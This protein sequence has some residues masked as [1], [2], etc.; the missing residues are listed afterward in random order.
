MRMSSRRALRS[1]ESSSACS[2]NTLSC[3]LSSS[4]SIVRTSC[5]ERDRMQAEGWKGKKSVTVKHWV[6][7][8]ERKF[9]QHECLAAS[10]QDRGIRRGREREMKS[11]AVQM[12]V[13]GESLRERD[14]KSVFSV[15]SAAL[16]VPVLA[17]QSEYGSWS[18]TLL[19]GWSRRWLAACS[20]PAQT[21]ENWITTLRISPP[22]TNKAA[23]NVS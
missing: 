22:P 23:V 5:R 7:T 13:I 19:L 17:V 11:K 16:W 10:Q 1:S 6:W 4:F 14:Q 8:V 21:H 3:T 18:L 15:P 20:R 9:L 2:S 12:C